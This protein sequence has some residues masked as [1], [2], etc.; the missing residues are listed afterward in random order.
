MTHTTDIVGTHPVESRVDRAV[1]ERC[2]EALM[3]CSQVCTTCADACLAESNVA[4]LQHC[5]RL[6]MDC[7]DVCAASARLLSRLTEPDWTLLRAQLQASVLATR[8]CA[9]ECHKHADHHEHCRVCEA[10]CLAAGKACTDVLASTLTT[11]TSAAVD[12]T[13]K[14]SFPASDPPSHSGAAAQSS[15]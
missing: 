4:D 6:D 15:R 1:V 2:I 13:A 8:L 12:E 3:D 14:E 11:D 9:Q 7:A 10:A 5:I